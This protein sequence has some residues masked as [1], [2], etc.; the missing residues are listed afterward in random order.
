MLVD[1]NQIWST[2]YIFKWTW[3]I[4]VSFGYII[5]IQELLKHSVVRI[6][7]A[8]RIRF[9]KHYAAHAVVFSFPFFSSDVQTLMGRFQMTVRLFFILV[10]TIAVASQ[11]LETIATSDGAT[12]LTQFLNWAQI[13]F[14]AILVWARQGLGIKTEEVTTT[15]TSASECCSQWFLLQIEI[16]GRKNKKNNISSKW[17]LQRIITIQ[18]LRRAV[19]SLQAQKSRKKKLRKNFRWRKVM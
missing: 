4:F 7:F 2:L 12:P 8:S 11:P 15:T 9:V 14:E 16:F 13:G 18:G 1:L 19:C 17:V 3:S 10:L 6:F 5:T